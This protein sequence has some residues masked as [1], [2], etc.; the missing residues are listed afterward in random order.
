MIIK[1]QSTDPERLGKKEQSMGN[2]WT[3]LRRGNRISLVASLGEDGN[4]KRKDQV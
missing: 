1:L 4:W 2:A 3:S